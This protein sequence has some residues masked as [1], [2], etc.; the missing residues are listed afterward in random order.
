METSL[1]NKNVEDR[2]SE[3]TKKTKKTKKKG[4]TE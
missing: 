3:N 1:K 2:G 4:T